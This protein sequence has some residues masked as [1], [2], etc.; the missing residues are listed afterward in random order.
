MSKNDRMP[1]SLE[2]ERALLGSL[3][4]DPDM[5]AF[6][7][8]T[9]NPNEFFSSRHRCIFRAMVGLRKENSTVELV[10]LVDAL[11]VKGEIEKAGG[12]AYLASLTDGVPI[13]SVPCVEEYVRIVK[14]KALA[15]SIIAEAQNLVVKALEGQDPL[16]LTEQATQS[17][18]RLETEGLVGLEDGK[19]YR[20]A[21]TSLL[22]S[23]D[24]PP[25]PRVKTG[26]DGL[27]GLTGGFLPGELVVFTA[28]TGVGKTLLAAQSRLF[29]CRSGLHTLF[30]SAEM[31]A[32][33]LLSREL[34]TEA[35]IPRWKLRQPEK[36]DRE[37]ILALMESAAH[38][39]D[40]CRI[41]D[42]EISI[43]RIR[44]AA[45]RMRRSGGL[46]LVIIDYDELIEAPGETELDQLRNVVIGAKR[47]AVEHG[48]PV[49]LIS[50]LRKLLKGEDRGRPTLDRLYST[51][52][53]PKH[54]SIVV[55]VDRKFV[56]EFQGDEAEA[57]I[58]VL[59]N[60]DGMVGQIEARFNVSSLRFETATSG[61]E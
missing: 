28:E 58:C 18:R 56:R 5:T 47:L 23:L 29:A 6:I 11:N 52:A 39:C 12:P 30:C 48:I 57:R 32:E 4:L 21:G 9:I 10:V 2:A 55:Y 45:Q 41:L 14:E 53:K 37:E 46:D 3:L 60:R 17:F 61:V 8:E 26:I 54:A 42:G 43:T 24:G 49:I 34:A 16:E 15:R 51:G 36:L 25:R 50:Q 59:K 33:H 31:D 22:A 35:G 38:Q 20:A 27:D 1:Q 13:G 44:S 7:F 19:T 40:R